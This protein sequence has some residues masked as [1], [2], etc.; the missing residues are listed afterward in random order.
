[1]LD[2]SVKSYSRKI[3]RGIK[4]GG[5]AVYTT[6]AK[7]KSAKISYSRIYVWR[8]C[9][10][11]LLECC[12]SPQTLCTRA[13][14]PPRSAALESNVLSSVTRPHT[15]KCLEGGGASQPCKAK[16]P[17]FGIQVSL[18]PK[19]FK[20]RRRRACMGMRLE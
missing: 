18:V 2:K 12:L 13:R 19:P 17:P 6:T 15:E 7:L 5:L 4:F 3:W 14:C 11:P 8:S 10:K 1:M 20:R 16:F 9:T